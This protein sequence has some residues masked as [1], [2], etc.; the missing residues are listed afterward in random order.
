[1]SNE[2][3][4]SLRE[5][6]RYQA[7]IITRKQ[8]LLSGISSNAIVSKV[9]QG[10]WQQVYAGV[11]AT[12]TGP[13]AR[14][15]QLW[16]A[17]LYAGPGARLS[18]GTAAELIRLAD[19]RSPLI[20]VTIPARRRVVSPTGV[21]I[22]RSAVLQVNWRFARGIP[23][24]TFAEETIVDLVQ[25][26]TDLDDVIAY[27]TGAFG[28]NL[29]SEARLRSEVDGRKKLRWRGNLDQIIPAGAGGTHSVLEYRYDLDVAQA[30]GLPAARKQLPFIKPNGGRGYRDRCHEEYGLVIELDG[31]QFHPDE[32]R[33]AD[34]DRDNHAIATGRA[35][36]RYGWIDVTQRACETARLEADALRSRG[37]TGTLKPCSPACRAVP[38]GIRP[39]GSTTASRL[40]RLRRLR[41][42]RLQHQRRVREVGKHRVRS[43]GDQVRSRV[44]AGRHPHGP[45]PGRQRRLDIKR[46]VTDYHGRRAGELRGRVSVD[47]RRPAAGHL[48]EFRAHLVVVAVGADAQVKP[49]A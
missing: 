35:T 37:W 30:H 38:P 21:V 12:F 9:K 24:H 41:Q 18:H 22:H 13:V 7:G 43:R 19:R 11:Y 25:A 47:G 36:L 26:A 1:M 8:A 42:Q 32:R 3:P 28:R 15:A 4:A 31:K 5:Q 40:R 44:G 29:T 46:R 6:A 33:G 27:V 14:D 20:H 23:P 48:D 16:A 49:V 34:E 2:M 17:V 39:A 45:R 10:R